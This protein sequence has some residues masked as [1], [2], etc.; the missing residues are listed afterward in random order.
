[1]LNELF[2]VLIVPVAIAIISV[3]FAFVE[4]AFA[5]YVDSLDPNSRERMRYCMESG[6]ADSR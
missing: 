6:T 3:A 5:E 4:S 2:Y 1:M